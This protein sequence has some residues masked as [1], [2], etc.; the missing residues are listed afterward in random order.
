MSPSDTVLMQTA[1]GRYE[2]YEDVLGDDQVITGLSQRYLAVTSCEWDVEP[3]SDSAADVEIAEFVESQLRC[4]GFDRVTFKMLFATFFGFSVAEIVWEPKEDGKR[5]GWKS[6]LVRKRQRFGFDRD[7]N[8]RLKTADNFIEGEECD[9]RY[10]WH[11]NYGADNDDDH[12]GKGLAHYLYWP[13]YFKRNGIKFWLIFLEK[14]GMPTMVGKFPAGVDQGQIDKL[15]ETAGAMATDAAVVVPNE[16]AIETVEA[17]RSGTADYKA[18]CEMMDAAISK[19]INNQTLTT[20]V[21]DSG[22]RA[23][24]DVHKSIGDNTAKSDADL[25]CESLNDG[26]IVQLVDANFAGVK[27]YPRVYRKLEPEEDLNQTADRDVKLKTMGYKRTKESVAEVY[28]E[29]Y[30][31]AEE[32]QMLDPN[33]PAS[34]KK[35]PAKKPRPQDDE[36]EQFATAEFPDQLALDQALDL[37]ESGDDPDALQATLEPVLQMLDKHGPEALL[38]RF[39]EVYPLNLRALQSRVAKLIFIAQVWGRVHGRE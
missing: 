23:L 34:G 31:E 12:Y 8:L 1:G 27:A 13:V 10:F 5:L 39:A 11:F 18:L 22:S 15:L 36:E 33:N 29:G 37:A 30:E 4:I 6:I 19:V 32:P 7:G 3:A 21:G 28:G 26:P 9:P 16:M 25:I 24:G 20:Q 2:V 17:K 35:P 38:A 14:F